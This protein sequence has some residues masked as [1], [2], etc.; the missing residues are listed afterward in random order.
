[1]TLP[2]AQRATFDVRF[3][4]KP[5]DE[6]FCPICLSVLKDPRLTSCCGRHFCKSCITRIQEM[7]QPC[8]ICKVDGLTTLFD[9]ELRN[10][11][12]T[13]TVH[14]PMETVGCRWVGKVEHLDAHLNVGNENGDCLFISIP[15]PYGCEEYHE[16]RIMDD[17]KQRKCPNRHLQ[18]PLC[19]QFGLSLSMMPLRDHY[20][21]CP[22]RRVSCPNQCPVR[23]KFYEL[24]EHVS[25]I[26]PYR[27]VA[28]KFKEIGCHTR[29]LFKDV[30][31][32]LVENA[33]SHLA[34][35]H[36]CTVKL[37]QDGSSLEE[38][39]C[40][41]VQ[42]SVEMEGQHHKLRE[43]VA[44][45]EERCYHNEEVIT[46]LCKTVHSLRNE[47]VGVKTAQATASAV[48]S[49]VIR[50]RSKWVQFSGHHFSLQDS[51]K[52]GREEEV[53]ERKENLCSVR[54]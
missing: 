32:H 1:M 50:R 19:F 11:I 17:H 27:E 44:V 6:F 34:L 46:E 25:S 33:H 45:L 18:C 30:P 40:Q 54:Y 14:C 7:G 43:R 48:A 4:E 8:P 53:E 2:P 42:S 24:A 22:N 20:P 26:C 37:A 10:R 38:R 12:N 28:C 13:L 3:I 9:R 15:C 47:I 5:P 49:D 35:V 23:V 29:V 39:Y 21:N 52:E 31:R 41:L 16:R 51:M 36:Q